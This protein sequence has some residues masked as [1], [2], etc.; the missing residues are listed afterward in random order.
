LYCKYTKTC[1]LQKPKGV[2]YKFPW[3]L[4]AFQPMRLTRRLPDQTY[5]PR[6]AHRPNRSGLGL[7]WQKSATRQVARPHQGGLAWQCTTASAQCVHGP[8][9]HMAQHG[10]R[11]LVRPYNPCH[12]RGGHWPY[13]PRRS[14]GS[15]SG[16]V[17]DQSSMRGNGPFGGWKLPLPPRCGNAVAT[18]PVWEMRCYA[19]LWSTPWLGTHMLFIGLCSIGHRSWVGQ[20]VKDVQKQHN[21]WTRHAQ[22]NHH[23]QSCMYLC[24][25][26]WLSNIWTRIGG[27][28]SWWDQSHVNTRHDVLDWFGPSYGVIALRPVL[29]YYAIEIGSSLFL[30]GSFG[31]ILVISFGCLRCGSIISIY[32]QG[33]IL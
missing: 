32:S 27:N 7:L 26:V 24:V 9:R 21:T 18:D 29:M 15:P 16:R 28:V 33:T 30:S 8:E 4:V 12:P 1:N 5:R 22:S 25:D 13:D 20:R 14:G 23:E 17:V 10:L 31:G 11:W 2:N 19:W 6:V 3:A